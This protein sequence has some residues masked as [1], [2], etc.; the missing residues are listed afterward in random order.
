MK[1]DNT[2]DT[3]DRTKHYSGVRMQQG[4]VQTDAD[5][6]EQIDLAEDRIETEAGHVI[7]AC[8]AP[9][10]DA[11]FALVLPKG[12]GLEIGAGAYYVDGILCRNEAQVPIGQQPDLPAAQI[13]RA[14]NAWV[15]LDKAPDGVYLAWLDVWMRHLTALEDPAIR[16]VALGGPDTATRAKT[17]WQVR[18]FQAAAGVGCLTDVPAWDQLVAPSTGK[19]SARA[20]PDPKST[21]PCIVAPGAGYRRLENQLYRVEIHQGGVLGKATF[22]WSRDN[23]SIVTAWQKKTGDDL[24]VA[25]LGRD[26][27]LG[28]AAGGWVE[29]TDGDREL[30]G[31][32]GTLV[33]LKDARGQTLTIDPATAT[34]TVDLADFP[35]G[36]KVRRWDGDG[37]TVVRNVFLPLEDGVEVRFAAGTYATG[38]YWLI[39]A[40]TATADVEWPL[41]AGKNPL[42][43][44]A[45]GIR[46]HVCR[47]A[48]VELQAGK[49]E[50]LSDC[51]NLFPPL[52]ELTALSYVSGD[53]QEAAPDFADLTKTLPLP[54]PL[55]A[56]IANGG[57][58]VQGATVRFT[59][60][61]GSGII[62]PGGGKTFETTTDTQGLAS[63]AWQ[64]DSTTPSQQVLAELLDAAGK[65][66]HLPVLFTANLSEASL[67]AYDPKDCKELADAKVK[68][69]QDAITTLCKLEH[70]EQECEVVVGP[71]QRFEQLDTAITT[72]LAEGRKV[73]CICLLPGD[74]GLANGLV[75]AD[76][77]Q[78][79][80][81]SIHG[82]GRGSRILPQKQ[83][84]FSSLAAFTLREVE[85]S[86]F[87]A[88]PS[89]IVLANCVEVEVSSC[90]FFGQ[91]S[92]PLLT[93]GGAQRV[94]FTNNHVESYTRA[95]IDRRTTIF[96]SVPE[97]AFLAQPGAGAPP[98]GRLAAA[99]D[100]LAARPKSEV[101]GIVKSLNATLKQTD[102]PLSPT[103][104]QGVQGV[105]ATLG[106]AGQAPNRD[107]LVKA[108]SDIAIFFPLVPMTAVVLL[109]GAA[110]ATFASNTITGTFGLYGDPGADPQPLTPDEQGML[111]KRKGELK[112]TTQNGALW[113]RGNR[114]TRVGLAVKM[115]KQIQA[116]LVPTNSAQPPPLDQLFRT[117]F[118]TE[119]VVE[120]GGDFWLAAGIRLT[121]ND[122]ADRAQDAGVAIAESAF[123]LGNSASNDIRL[124]SA[125]HGQQQ[126]TPNA[127]NLTINIVLL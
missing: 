36:P 95:S 80:R 117:L 10:H 34:G 109:D 24:T 113:L 84:S 15:T 76:P 27:V 73:L 112:F 102:A 82:C 125:S 43:Q 5:W 86:F 7:G 42:P 101:T 35:N 64:L 51:R 105:L 122:F 123:Y 92:S 56:G 31:Q 88:V 17:V 49:W 3:F 2:R 12:R 53:G 83:L 45:R 50:V 19:L 77:T 110:D 74:Y 99:A 98:A 121:T 115:F 37:E 103:E 25:S 33:R 78:V 6:N 11:G 93:I 57:L 30:T 9:I 107:N 18:L 120:S 29:L 16:E 26:P 1:A 124:F 69:V 60:T 70:Q 63:C 52:T 21:D 54:Q 97:I 46:H 48:M 116:W 66:L 47:L 22:T 106:T 94:R 85:V 127:V 87:S 91:D 68:T 38:D 44:P 111:I 65:R 89:A 55:V 79:L 71:G 20:T 126:T 90:H 32:P 100:T 81:L 72:L 39:P 13:V 114:L 59:V 40:R 23:G 67:V 58:P 8:G 108:F 61:V 118:M 119:S 4:R 62:L 41:G 28:F 104:T 96:A 14:G 75:L